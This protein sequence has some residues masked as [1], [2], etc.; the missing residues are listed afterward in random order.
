MMTGGC[1]LSFRVH[2]RRVFNILARV[3]NPQY[4]QNARQNCIP[5]EFIGDMFA[6]S[7]KGK[8]AFLNLEFHETPNGSLYIWALPDETENLTNRYAV[9]VDIGGRTHTADWSVIKVFDRYWMKD[10][11]KPEVVAVWTGHLDQD[12]VSWKAAQI[13]SFYN[14]ALLVIEFN[15]SIRR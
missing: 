5:P 11:G 2:G 7:S 9:T 4:V 6:S 15:S 3:F 14:D 13:A 8:G 10:G 12:L 1:N